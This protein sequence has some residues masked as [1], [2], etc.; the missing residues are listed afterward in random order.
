MTARMAP[1][2]KHQRTALPYAWPTDT[3]SHHATSAT[4]LEEIMAATIA[5]M[6]MQNKTKTLRTVTSLYVRDVR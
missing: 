4:D 5:H 1:S 6:H 2:G 3:A